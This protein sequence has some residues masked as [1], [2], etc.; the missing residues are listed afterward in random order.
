M[1]SSLE[2]IVGYIMIITLN[3]TY[4]EEHWRHN[5]CDGVSNHQPRDLI[6]FSTVYPGA[7]QRKH[8]SSASLAFVQG[9]HRWPVNSPHKWPV[10]RK[11]FPFDDIIMGVS[12]DFI[13][14]ATAARVKVLPQLTWP[15]SFKIPGH[16]IHEHHAVFIPRER[17]PHYWRFGVGIHWSPHR[18]PVMWIY[19]VCFVIGPNKLLNIQLSWWW[20][21]TPWRSCDFNLKVYGTLF[22]P[23]KTMRLEYIEGCS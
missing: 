21:E 6:V 4:F 15:I 16:E 1:C 2:S 18:G 10:T 11:M 22:Y 23:A 17:F 5:G 19:D 12:S 7:D 8:L 9:I 13:A 20:F 14:P 3:Y